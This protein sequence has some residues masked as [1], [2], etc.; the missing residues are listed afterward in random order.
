ME[1]D[2]NGELLR[3]FLEVDGCVDAIENNYIDAEV[4]EIVDGP[5]FDRLQATTTRSYYVH[6]KV[7][8]F[9]FIALLYS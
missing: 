7:S 3:E 2:I 9:T 8:A 6:E 4:D 5:I 1:P